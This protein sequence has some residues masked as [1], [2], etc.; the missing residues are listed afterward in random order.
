MRSEDEIREAID[1]LRDVLAKVGL[2]K[3]TRNRIEAALGA[4]YYAL[5]E[6]GCELADVQSALDEARELL[7]PVED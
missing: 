6:R 4:L 2:T 7:I 1:T 3:R 5:G